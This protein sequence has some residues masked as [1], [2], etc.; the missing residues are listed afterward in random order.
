MEGGDAQLAAMDMLPTGAAVDI[1]LAAGWTDGLLYGIRALSIIGI[2]GRLTLSP[3]LKGLPIRHG[4]RRGLSWGDFG[5]GDFHSV[6]ND[7]TC[8][9]QF[10]PIYVHLSSTKAGTYVCA[11]M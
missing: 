4:V 9:S 6:Y 5:W 10:I 11:F 1:L 3:T 8:T 7:C 2:I